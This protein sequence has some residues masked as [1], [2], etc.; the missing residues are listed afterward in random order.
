MSKMQTIVTIVFCFVRVC[1]L[2]TSMSYAGIAE[3][4]KSRCQLGCGLSG[5]HYRPKELCITLQVQIPPQ[6][7]A[8]LQGPCPDLPTVD[9]LNV[10]C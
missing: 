1:L 3:P 2:V 9:I 5:V 8:L 7:E 10:I 4:V 6:D